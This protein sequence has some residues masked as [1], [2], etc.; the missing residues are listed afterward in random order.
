MEKHDRLG[1]NSGFS[2]HIGEK[3][4]GFRCNEESTANAVLE[5]LRHLGTLCGDEQVQRLVSLRVGPPPKRRG[6]RNYNIVY[7]GHRMV[8]KT[9]NLE[10]AVEEATRLVQI[11]SV[12]LRD[13]LAHVACHLFAVNEGN[14][15]ICLTGPREECSSLIGDLLD[16][17]EPESSSFASLDRE[18]MC[19]FRP[20]YKRGPHLKRHGMSALTDFIHLETG[21]PIQSPGQLL[22]HLYSR[23]NG[24]MQGQACLD[25]IGKAVRS[26]TC[27][28]LTVQDHEGRLAALRQL[29]ASEVQTQ[30]PFERL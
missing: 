3:K 18:G 29:I 1:W 30:V 11:E 4:L 10:E 8:R 2:L 21:D 6:S 14:R 17:V 19:L 7:L 15:L 26:A 28:V 20:V 24:G 22:L 5:T 25:A 12:L 13:D 23:T 9:L 27:R 16:E